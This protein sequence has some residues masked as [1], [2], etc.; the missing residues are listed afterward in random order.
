M[1]DDWNKVNSD[2]VKRLGK[3]RAGQRPAVRPAYPAVGAPI[4]AESRQPD[5]ELARVTTP[6][7]LIAKRST[8]RQ[9]PCRVLA[10]SHGKVIYSTPTRHSRADLHKEI[11]SF[12]RRWLQR[13][14]P[15]LKTMQ[16]VVYKLQWL[17][18]DEWIFD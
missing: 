17:E 18:G 16:E 8:E 15:T 12:Q 10:L 5:A 13:Q 11:I 1:S 2:L 7:S 6:N 4:I 14:Y 3:P 9:K